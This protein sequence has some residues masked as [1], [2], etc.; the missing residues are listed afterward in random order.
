MKLANPAP[1]YSRADE[2]ERNRALELADMQNH[3]RGRD[4]EVGAGRVIIKSPDGTR[5][6]IT[7]SNAGVVGASAV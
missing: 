7:V 1:V 3:K 5:W 4:I 6:E 2:F